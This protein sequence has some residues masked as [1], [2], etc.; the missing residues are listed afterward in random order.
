M[1]QFQFNPLM[2]EVYKQQHKEMI[3]QAEQSRLV[4][5]ASRSSNPEAPSKSRFLALIGKELSSLG[6]SLEVRFGAQPEPYTS[7]NQ[8]RNPG[9]CA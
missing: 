8:Q 1:Q 4:K 3:M 9:G 6:F 5:E 7:L 2:Y